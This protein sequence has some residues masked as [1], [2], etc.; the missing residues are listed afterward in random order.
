MRKVEKEQPA[1][2][3]LSYGQRALWFMQRMVPESA[4]Y[5][6]SR[7]FR[8]KAAVDVEALRDAFQ[9]LVDGHPALRTTIVETAGEPLQHVAEKARVSF[10]YHDATNWDNAELTL[11]LLE[12]KRKP[13]R[14]AEGPL[15]RVVYRLAE[16]RLPH[17]RDSAP[18]RQR[19]VVA[20]A[21]F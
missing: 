8:I 14:L 12:Q 19:L 21:A 18:H 11:E 3:P 6:I 15:F 20:H 10:E 4:V 13:F 9:A 2:Y 7:T 17:A 16:K 1:T 5:N